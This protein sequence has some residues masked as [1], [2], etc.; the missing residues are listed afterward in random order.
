MAETDTATLLLHRSVLYVPADRQ[1]A[2][3]K[4]A[5]TAAD[6]II[7]DLEDAVAPDTK[8][9]GRANVA[10]L[11]ARGGYARKQ[12]VIRVNGLDTPDVALDLVA[13]SGADAILVPK[14][15]GVEDVRRAEAGISALAGA[16]PRPALWA[17]VETP[18]AI[19]NVATIAAEA[20]RRDGRLKAFVLGTND[21]VKETGVQMMANRLPLLTWMSQTVV[22]ARA[23]GLTVLDGVF[24]II[25]SAEGLMAECRQGRALG[26]DGKTLIHPDQV[27]PANLVFGPSETEIAEAKAI[28][29]AFALPENA[30]KGVIRVAGRMTERLHLAMAERL[31]KRAALAEASTAQ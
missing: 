30:G 28:V 22:A 25:D 16:S 19:L 17:M 4:A 27:A 2:I 8:A 18:L 29:E 5:T 24:N 21:L 20:A 7:V 15:N 31:L 10:A 26:F 1:R 13:A 6:V 9:E 3:E 14:I 23:Y 12:L 11:I